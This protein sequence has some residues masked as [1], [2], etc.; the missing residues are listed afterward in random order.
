MYAAPAAARVPSV[1]ETFT[2]RLP[3]SNVASASATL[4]LAPSNH[5]V[6]AVVQNDAEDEEDDAVGGEEDFCLVLGEMRRR[7]R[8]R[9]PPC[10]DSSDKRPRIRKRGDDDEQVCSVPNCDDQIR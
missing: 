8:R 4:K 10:C 5:R 9:R 6:S 7:K 1:A 2:L 3:Q